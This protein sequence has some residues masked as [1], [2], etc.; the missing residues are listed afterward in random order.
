MDVKRPT[1][2]RVHLPY[3][4][5]EIWCRIFSHLDTTS[6]QKFALT[7][8]SFFAISSDPH[9][10]GL[11]FMQKYGKQLALYYA[12]RYHRTALTPE[13][14]KLMMRRGAWLPRFLVQLVDKEVS[15]LY[16]FYLFGGVGIEEYHRQ[17][18]G[19]RSVPV[20]L[21]V[22]FINEGYRIYGHTAD[23]K[24]DDVARFERLLY[25][26]ATP[27]N[28]PTV[29]S[30]RELL[31]AFQFVP[32]RGS[33]SP[34][35]ETVYLISKLDMSLVADLV[36][37]GLDLTAVNDQVMERV[38]WRA[39]VS[40]ET[41]Q[42]YLQN[43]FKL[44]P[45][46]IKKG[47]QMARPTTL[48]ALRRRIP[49]AELQGF[50]E[51]TI[52]DMFGPSTGR[53][54]NWV[55][56]SADYLMRVFNI[57]EDV[58]ARALYTHPDDEPLPNGGR[59]EFPATRCYMKANPCPVWR[60]VLKTYGP[61]HPFTLASFDDALSRAA[62]DRDLHAVHDTFLESGVKFFPR[63]VKILACRVLHRDMTS[64]ALHLLRVLRT[65]VSQDLLDET[66]SD[67]DREAWARALQ[68]EVVGNEEWDHRMRTTQLEGGARG[69]AFRISKPPED[70]LM[71]LNESRELLA[72][73]L[74]VSV[75]GLRRRDSSRSSRQ[76]S[77][78]M[79]TWVRRMST[80]WRDQVSDNQRGTW[81]GMEDAG[82]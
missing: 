24:E 76:T 36:H 43:G 74:P 20:P 37:N 48:D 28:T 8:R 62:A 33:G 1:P 78:S 4:P 59:A 67:D 15:S 80:W 55:P 13:V 31:T 63:H 49:D 16:E 14:G 66:L 61:S 34:L 54:W 71:F 10:R 12:F 17:E 69:G 56:E 60:W 64:N 68:E 9:A 18:R 57:S 38:L 27:S 30:I 3:C 72:D 65:Q 73:L 6:P 50:A 82:G 5:Y 23:F 81:N 51:D 32:V 40:D 22:F 7:S 29:E 79:K 75:T 26:S 46:A 35:D 70:A 52:V 42:L 53:G 41:L 58:V 44:S 19:K 77:P 25:G 45:I 47:L 21:F 2:I 39:D 11:Y